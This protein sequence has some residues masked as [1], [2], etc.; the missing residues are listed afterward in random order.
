MSRDLYRAL[1]RLEE[2]Q[3]HLWAIWVKNHEA[4]YAAWKSKDR[5]S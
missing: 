1:R 2:M 4:E 3:P 5:E